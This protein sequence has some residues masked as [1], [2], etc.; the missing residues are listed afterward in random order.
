MRLI[1]KRRYSDEYYAVDVEE[2]EAKKIPDTL[3]SAFWDWG[4]SLASLLLL[5][6]FAS[7]R[8]SWVH[9]GDAVYYGVG[10]YILV[11]VFQF[12]HE[13]N[14]N[15]RYVRHQNRVLRDAWR[16]VA[17]EVLRYNDPD[18]ATV[19]TLIERLDNEWRQ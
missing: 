15:V 8:T 17:D 9:W 7:G 18:N 3:S 6:A 5:V 1:P 12:L 11:K 10:L 2:W 19:A 16:A 14:E 4:G 13:I